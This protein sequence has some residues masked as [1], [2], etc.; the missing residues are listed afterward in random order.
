MAVVPLFD[1]PR[2]D[3]KETIQECIAKGIAVK[4]ITGGLW[5]AKCI[6]GSRQLFKHA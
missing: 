4:M 5:G 1:P 2:H 6:T 3:T